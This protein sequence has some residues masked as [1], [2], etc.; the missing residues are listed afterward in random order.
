[1]WLLCFTVCHKFAC[2]ITEDYTGCLEQLFFL[3]FNII[4]C[5][6][7]FRR[8]MEMSRGLYGYCVLRFAINLHVLLLKII[9]GVWNNYFFQYLRYYCVKNCL[10]EK[11]KCQED[12]VA[13][14]FCGF[15]EICM[16][17]C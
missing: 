15:S 5:K 7:I 11:W 14:V 9:L 3:V 17:Y 1:M 4:L 12:C 16:C 10:G 6:K 2:V 13:T 8:K